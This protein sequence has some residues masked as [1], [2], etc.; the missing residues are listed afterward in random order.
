MNQNEPLDQLADFY[1]SLDSIPTPVL[2]MKPPSR[3][4]HWTL[5]FAPLSAAILAYGFISF[6]A[7]GPTT[8]NAAPMMM[9]ITIDRYA[10]GEF[11]SDEPSM[12]PRKHASTDS[13]KG[14]VI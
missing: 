1:K 14:R 8:P 13:T 4:G 6:C 5:A 9:Q 3:W 2:A 11:R 12:R 7:S 10:S